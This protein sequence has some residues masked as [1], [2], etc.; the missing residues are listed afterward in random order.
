VGRVVLPVVETGPEALFRLGEITTS[1]SGEF[2]GSMSLGPWLEM[3]GGVTAGV[4][5]VLVDDVLGFALA[6]DLPRGRWSVSA[7]IGLEVLRPLPASGTVRVTGALRHQDS[8]GALATGEVR[9]ATGALLALTSQRGRFVAAPADLVEEG[10]W[11]GPVAEGDLER[12]LAVRAGVP[13]AITDVLANEGGSLH[14]GVSLFASV[15]V[16]EAAAPGLVTAS[17][18][19]TY[20]RAIPLGVDVTWRPSVRHPGRSL[21]VVDVDGMVGDRVCTTARVV[22]HPA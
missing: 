21:A 13:L 18:H 7:E 2:A 10:S 22:L 20:A 15:L 12:L 4:L 19:I 14:G 11:G 9:D 8:L 1:D 17:A 6:E 5:A 3:A 16:A